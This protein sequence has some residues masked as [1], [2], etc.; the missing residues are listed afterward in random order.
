MLAEPRLTLE[1]AFTTAQSME[2][3]EKGSK[4]M[5]HADN[6]H[7]IQEGGRNRKQPGGADDFHPRDR[8]ISCHRCGGK[9]HSPDAC[10]YKNYKCNHCNLTGHL[11]KVC[12]KKINPPST[13][14]RKVAPQIKWT[15]KRRKSTNYITHFRT[16]PHPL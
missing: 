16:P 15:S 9:S 13:Y 12:R 7:V 14:K 10:K 5:R 4:D 11:Q 8:V 6:V 1:K 2:L 3:A